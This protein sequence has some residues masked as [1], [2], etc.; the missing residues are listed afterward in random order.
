MSERL[1]DSAEGLTA[2]V[3]NAV[4]WV[5]ENAPKA[6]KPVYQVSALIPLL[7]PDTEHE[8]AAEMWGSIQIHGTTTTGKIVFEAPWIV[9]ELDPSKFVTNDEWWKELGL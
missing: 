2:M 7:D 9:I 4:R 8:G 3:E 1:H 5:I 6:P